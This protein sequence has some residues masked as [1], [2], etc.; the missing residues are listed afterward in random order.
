MACAG[1]GSPSSAG[2]MFD[3][4]PRTLATQSGEIGRSGYMERVAV[5][6]VAYNSSK[7]IEACVNPCLRDP[8][9]V[10]VVVVDNSSEKGCSEA[11]RR[12][13]RKDGRVRYVP[14]PNHGFSRGCNRGVA[15]LPPCDVVVFL[16]PD[17]ELVQSLGSLARHLRT[18]SD[19]I[20][21][22]RLVPSS[23]LPQPTCRIA[24]A[25]KPFSRPR[26]LLASIIGPD[27]AYAVRSGG[28]MDRPSAISVGQVAGALLVISIAD[29]VALNGYDE[30]FELY[31]DDVDLCARAISLGGISVINQTWG[32]HQGGGSSK[33]VSAM[34]YSAWAV[35]RVRYIGKHYGH[36]VGTKLYVAFLASVEYVVRSISCRKEGQSVRTK[37]LRLQISEV[38]RP[39]TVRVLF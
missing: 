23:G 38:L 28:K 9:V 5:V 10:G 20:V 25:R 14:S 4:N 22:G 19:V 12:L 32:T 8:Q 31:Y 18:S 34:A 24:N 17:V 3:P 26:E 11:V 6:I 39:G 27:R 2:V 15:N 1:R 35:S 21:S 16:N 33:S 30:R 13:A 36:G 37:A 29:F 7:T